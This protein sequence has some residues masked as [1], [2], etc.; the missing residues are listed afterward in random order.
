MRIMQNTAAKRYA[1]ALYELATETNRATEIK[2]QLSLLAEVWSSDEALGQFLTNPRC[3]LAEKKELLS[4]LAKEVKLNQFVAN[5]L[6]LMLDKGRITLLPEISRSY[7]EYDDHSNNRVR[8][9]CR[10]ATSLEEKEKKLLKQ[11]LTKLS[12]ASEVILTAETDASLMAGF[13]LSYRGVT[14]DGSLSGRLDRLQ[15]QMLNPSHND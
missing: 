8:G 2:G 13:V 1:A 5:T 10:A 15:R 4:V 7:T 9:H 11:V 12:Q 6:F 14:I 3:S